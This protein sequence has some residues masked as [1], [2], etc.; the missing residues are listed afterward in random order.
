MKDLLRPIVAGGLVVFAFLIIAVGLLHHEIAVGL[1]RHDA[2]LSAPI[3]LLL[4][5][6]GV[7]VY[8]LPT[9]LAFYRDCKATA[10]IAAV[11]I[12]LGWTIFGWVVSIGWAASGKTR[13]LPPTVA[14]PPSHPIPGH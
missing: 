10:W 1:H 4:F 2:D 3:R 12:L 6:V 13:T 5:V 14:A 8:L 7:T 9:V 11:N